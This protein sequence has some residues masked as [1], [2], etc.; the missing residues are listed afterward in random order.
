MLACPAKINAPVNHPGQLVNIA[1][2]DTG[3]TKSGPAHKPPWKTLAATDPE[4]LRRIALAPGRSQAPALQRRLARTVVAAAAA[5]GRRRLTP[6]MA[7]I[8]ERLAA[9]G[10]IQPD[11]DAPLLVHCFNEP[12]AAA[13]HAAEL[14][15]IRDYCRAN[16]P[17]ATTFNGL[18]K[19]S[20]KWHRDIQEIQRR[21]GLE[22]RKFLQWDSAIDSITLENGITATAL[23][24]TIMLGLESRL[25][26]HCVF[27]YDEYCAKGRTRIFHLSTGA[28]AQL[29]LQQHGQW[30]AGQVRRNRNHPALEA[31]KEATAELAIRYTEAAQQP[32]RRRRRQPD[33]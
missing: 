9:A 25:Q 23:T 21:E 32:R 6:E 16:R 18:V 13:D 28:T 5:A 7:A 33:Q 31:E 17:T 26:N 29:L 27:Q 3:W 19:A 15:E 24:D 10:G 12:Q 30:T 20:H 4:V 14:I 22:R 2:K 11:N 1:R 8:C